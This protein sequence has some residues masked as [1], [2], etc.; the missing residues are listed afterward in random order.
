M[1]YLDDCGVSRNNRY[2]ILAEDA[3]SCIPRAVFVQS[4]DEVVGFVRPLD[5]TTGLPQPE[6]KFSACSMQMISDYFKQNTKAEHVYAL[7]IVPLC[8]EAKDFVLALFGTDN[9]FTAEDCIAR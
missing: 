7:V 3:T 4:I 8:R 1:R 2:A 5:K 9:K 6:S